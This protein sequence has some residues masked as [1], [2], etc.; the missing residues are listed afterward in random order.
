[1]EIFLKKA[2]PCFPWKSQWQKHAIQVS[3]QQNFI[4]KNSLQFALRVNVIQTLNAAIQH[5][6]LTRI[7]VGLNPQQESCFPAA[8]CHTRWFSQFGSWR[9][10]LTFLALRSGILLTKTF[11][12]SRHEKQI[13]GSMVF[14]TKGENEK[15]FTNTPRTQGQNSWDYVILY[16]KKNRSAM[17]SWLEGSDFSWAHTTIIV[18]KWKLLLNAKCPHFNGW[19]R[20]MCN[21]SCSIQSK[22]FP[23]SVNSLHLEMRRIH[24]P[25]DKMGSP[26]AC[27][28]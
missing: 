28:C 2:Q 20:K 1:M 17:C 9:H 11:F 26:A 3:C 25:K 18:T 22:W 6:Y 13:A 15:V 12:G 21:S 5:H 8:L 27:C 19:L 10:I 7:I 4:Q 16:G 23:A 24:L 14:D